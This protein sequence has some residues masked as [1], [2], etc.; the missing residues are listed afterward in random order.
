MASFIVNV[1]KNTFSPTP[2]GITFPSRFN[3]VDMAGDEQI[4]AYNILVTYKNGKMKEFAFPV[5]NDKSGAYMR[6]IHFYCRQ[7]ERIEAY[8]ILHSNENTK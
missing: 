6:A 2:V 1:I 4:E 8:N 5:A 3:M 7:K